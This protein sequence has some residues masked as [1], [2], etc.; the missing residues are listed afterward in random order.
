MARIVVKA[1]VRRARHGVERRSVLK[2]YGVARS[3]T[4]KP[5]YV[6]TS[7][8][9]REAKKAGIEGSIT[10]VGRLS[11]GESPVAAQL[12]SLAAQKSLTRSHLSGTA[13]YNAQ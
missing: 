10:F 12:R 1:A 4:G 9:S 7:A 11:K 13:A 5:C 2:R 8:R 6:V 3:R